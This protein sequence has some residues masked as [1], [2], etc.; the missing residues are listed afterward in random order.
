M[1]GACCW[2]RPGARSAPPSRFSPRRGPSSPPS[3]APDG[4]IEPER[5]EAHQFAGHGLAWVAAS[6][7]GL[8]QIGN[9]ARRLDDGAE[10]GEAEAL[11]LEIA[12]GEYL[13]QLAGGIP[14]AQGEFAR[15]HDLGLS[16][17]AAAPLRT[18]D[19]GALMAAL[20]AAR[21]RLG[22]VLAESG[23]SGFGRIGLD[24]ATL[25]TDPRPGAP[26]CRARGHALRPGLAPPRPADP[27][28][29]DRGIGRDRRL[30]HDHPR[31]IWRAR[32]RQDRDVRRL[33]GI[34]ARPISGS[35]R[36]APARRSP[37]S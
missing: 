24:D 27:A 21:L 1:T 17:S 25:D 3:V 12:Y 5:F 8:R 20:P 29:V 30:R 10:F 4:A 34:V 6:V 35:A 22:A 15:P 11:I 33:G 7:E 13:A 31:R 14:M 9:W 16:E 19:A 32:P 36:S 26:L 37:A 2:R 23:E 28:A 18:G